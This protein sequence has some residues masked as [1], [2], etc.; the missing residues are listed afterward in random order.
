MSMASKVTFAQRAIQDKPIQEMLDYFRDTVPKD[1]AL[2][3]NSKTNPH[4]AHVAQYFKS[5]GLTEAY[6]TSFWIAF[7]RDLPYDRG[8]HQKLKK[9]NAQTI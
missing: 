3:G 5:Q 2:R 9:L 7:Q 1:V 4:R 8:L 6:C